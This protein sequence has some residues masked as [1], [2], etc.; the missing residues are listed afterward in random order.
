MVVDAVVCPG[1]TRYVPVPPVP[2]TSA[3]ILVPCVTPVPLRIMPTERDGEPTGILVTV[4]VDP[5]IDAVNSMV[6]SKVSTNL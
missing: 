6:N 1:D 5:V 3:V 4:S 2:L